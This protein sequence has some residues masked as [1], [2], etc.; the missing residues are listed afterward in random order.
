MSDAPTIDRLRERLGFLE[1]E[2]QSGRYQSGAWRA[3]LRDLGRLPRTDRTALA[4]AI[5]HASDALHARTAKWTAPISAGLIAEIFLAALG[6][7]LLR[8]AVQ[9]GQSWCAVATALLWAM[10]FQPL[11]KVLI[12]HLLGIRYSYAYL[13]GPEPR[14]KMRYGTYIAASRSARIAF[15]LSGTIGSPIGAWLPTR[16]LAGELPRATLI[17]WILFGV[18]VTINIVPFVAALAGFDRIGPL[19]LSLG[20]A[21]SAALEIR[22]AAGV[23][24]G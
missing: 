21:G 18:A 22:E 10:T 15:H 23:S 5:S 19:R 12:G 20:S 14:F 9:H 17:C 3:L 4:G 8:M 1:S 6:A 13:L 11:A 24:A 16:F 2:I 7:L